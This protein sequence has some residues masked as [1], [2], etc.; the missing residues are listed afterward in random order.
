[1]VSQT[2]TTVGQWMNQNRSRP[3][4]LSQP[5]GVKLHNLECKSVLARRD[6]K[7]LRVVRIT[8]LETFLNFGV[9]AL[10]QTSLRGALVQTSL[11]LSTAQRCCENKDMQMRP[12]DACRNAFPVFV[13]EKIA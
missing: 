4:G 11:Q 5:L 6:V 13:L 10:V 2:P 3:L 12:F 9:G 7:P 8:L 1:M